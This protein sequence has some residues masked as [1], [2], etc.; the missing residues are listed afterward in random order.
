MIEILKTSAVVKRILIAEP[1]A[2]D[3]DNLL[4]LKVW[5]EQE[6]KLRDN[7]YAFTKFGALFMEGKFTNTESI[8][9]SRAKLQ[10]EI[11]SLRGKNYKGRQNHQEQI[12][13]ELKDGSMIAGGTP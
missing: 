11:P 1:D 8:R 3:N 13:M 12:Q 4:I 5:C 6:P 7:K 10:E 2:R 9:R